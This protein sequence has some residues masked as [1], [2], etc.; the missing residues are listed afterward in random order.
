MKIREKIYVSRYINDWRR[1]KRSISKEML[2]GLA[3]EYSGYTLEGVCLD[4]LEVVYD[5]QNEV[6]DRKGYVEFLLSRE[7]DFTGNEDVDFDN[8]LY[9][10]VGDDC[11]YIDYDYKF[12]KSY[13]G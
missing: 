8:L 3:E 11:D 10:F 2:Q 6:Y 1:L 13:R 5:E 4:N 9:S 7:V 12:K